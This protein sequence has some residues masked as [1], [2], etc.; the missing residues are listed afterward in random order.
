M[1]V[2]VGRVALGRIFNVT[3]SVVDAYEEIPLSATFGGSTRT[4]REY[5]QSIIPKPDNES[6]LT[7]S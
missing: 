6:S 2:P 1:V 7:F 4:S 5:A 3:G